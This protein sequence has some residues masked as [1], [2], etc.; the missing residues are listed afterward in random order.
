MRS[1][2]MFERR[3]E[4]DYTLDM[5]FILLGHRM[6]PGEFQ[7]DYDLMQKPTNKNPSK[8]K[9]EN[10]R[11]NEEINKVEEQC[12]AL[13]QMLGTADPEQN[14]Q[15]SIQ[16]LIDANRSKIDALHYERAR[17]PDADYVD[18]EVQSYDRQYTLINTIVTALEKRQLKAW[19]IGLG[20]VLDKVWRHAPHHRYCFLSSTVTLP[21]HYGNFFEQ[22]P[23]NT[24]SD[25]VT[26][27]VRIERDGFEDWLDQEFPIDWKDEAV[28]GIDRARSWFLP[29]CRRGEKPFKRR[30]LV[31]DFMETAFGIKG[32][33]A[34]DLWTRYAPDNWRKSGRL[35]HN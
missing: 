29:Y 10:E 15:D 22:D 11:I 32:A 21:S 8:V 33:Q 19:A 35:R 27:L 28:P 6:F 7:N 9:A 14:T 5:V 25:L 20:D 31:L 1:K 16:S 23:E 26:R 4:R 34:Q 2:S 30:D 17:I 13:Q 24:D 18:R 12:R 3:A